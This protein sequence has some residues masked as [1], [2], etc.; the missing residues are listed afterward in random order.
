MKSSPPSPLELQV[1]SVLWAHGPSTV[2][3]VLDLLPDGRTRAYTTALSVLQTM[4]RKGLVSRRAEGKAHVYRPKKTEKQILA[5][6][7]KELVSNVFQ[8][9]PGKLIE[10]TLETVKLTEEEKKSVS[11]SLRA[12]KPRLRKRK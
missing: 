5:P 4:E 7:V 2:R 11:S 6:L 8:G 1:L 12:H 3:Q 10:T 9:S